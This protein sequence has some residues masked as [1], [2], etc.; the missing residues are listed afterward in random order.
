MKVREIT[1]KVQERRS[2]WYGHV[3]RR[4]ERCVGRR[5]MK[6]KIRGKKKKGRPKRGWFDKAKDDREGTVG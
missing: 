1:N 5:A 2:K 4:E 6:M 3:M